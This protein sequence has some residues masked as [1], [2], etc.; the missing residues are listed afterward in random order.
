M[1]ITLLLPNIKY[2]QSINIKYVL[3]R[4]VQA[5]AN[6]DTR[7]IPR[8]WDVVWNSFWLEMSNK[9]ISRFVHG[10][11]SF[12]TYAEFPSGSNVQLERV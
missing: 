7:V 9:P 4:N 6:N 1:A 10:F 11:A 12:G 2:A 8:T 5:F 3:S